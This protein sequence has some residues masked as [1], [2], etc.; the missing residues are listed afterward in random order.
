MMP[1]QKLNQLSVSELGKLI[2]SGRIS[3]LEAVKDCLEAIEN[4]DSGIN[5]FKDVF[6]DQAQEQAAKAEQQISRGDYQGPLHGVPFAVKD[7]YASKG[8]VN[9]AGSMVLKDSPPARDDAYVVQ[10]LKRAGAILLGRLNMHEL[11]FGIT[12]RNPHF[13]PTLNPHDTRLMCGGSSSGS[14]AALAANMVPLTLGSDTGGSIRIPSALCGVAGL[15]PTYGLFSKTG[16]VP[17]AWSL[18]TVGPMARGVADLALAMDAMAGMDPADPAQT[19]HGFNRPASPLPE[20]RGSLKGYTVGV[21]QGFFSQML[22]PE[23]EDLFQQSLRQMSAMGAE[24]RELELD[25]VIPA[26]RAA[27]AI[28]FSEAAACLEV[29]TR[30]QPENLGDE[31]RAAVSL[32]MT[33]PA[34]RYV[35]ALRVRAALMEQLRQLFMDIDIMAVPATT[36][37]APPIDVEKVEVQPGKTLDV[38]AALTRFTR[39]FNIAGV[40]VLC[41]PCGKTQSGL[42]VGIQLASG[43]F[44]EAKLLRFGQELEQA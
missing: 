43:Y 39:Y 9:Q 42:P 12:S 23:V 44:E 5:A 37:P 17:L 32:G 34:T 25:G 20:P 38:R 22:S 14:G 7:L 4:T 2:K 24:L 31:V 29:H 19:R 15:K 26:D 11:A 40:P 21:P 36:I 1:Q 27:M 18:D 3:P 10:G 35:Q 8:M 13:G 30:N 16:V 33:I 6:A 41:M 28:L